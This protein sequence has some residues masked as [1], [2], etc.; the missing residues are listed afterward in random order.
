[1]QFEDESATD[2]WGEPRHGMMP[3]EDAPADRR[4]A[5]LAGDGCSRGPE[6]PEDRPVAGASVHGYS[7]LARLGWRRAGI[8]YEARVEESGRRVILL[9]LPAPLADSARIARFRREAERLVRLRHPHLQEVIAAGVW[10][11]DGEAVGYLVVPGEFGETLPEHLLQRRPDAASRVRLLAGVC[12]GLEHAHR[13]GL[14]HGDLRAADLLV[15]LD[16]QARLCEVGVARLHRIMAGSLPEVVAATDPLP[17]AALPP[18][19]SFRDVLALGE[20]ARSVLSWGDG[21]ASPPPAAGRLREMLAASPWARHEGPLGLARS[22][23]EAVGGSAGGIAAGDRGRRREAGRGLRRLRDASVCVATGAACLS[24][25]LAIAHLGEGRPDLRSTI[26]S[27]AAAPSQGDAGPDR[28]G[29]LLAEDLPAALRSAGVGREV[30]LERALD[31]AAAPLAAEGWAATGRDAAEAAE[32]HEAIAAAYESIG[33]DEAAAS[34]RRL[35]VRALAGEAVPRRLEAEARLARSLLRLRRFEEAIAVLAAAST[36]ADRHLDGDSGITRRIVHDLAVARFLEGDDAAAAIATLSRLRAT[37]ASD[38]PD[39]LGDGEIA[40]SLSAVLEATG[41]IEEAEAMLASSLASDPAASSVPMDAASRQ[42]RL[43]SLRLAAGKPAEA[44]TAAETAFAIACEGLGWQHPA[45]A[46]MAALLAAV[47]DRSGDHRRAAAIAAS[48][49]AAAPQLPAV[50]AASLEL[51][52]MHAWALARGGDLAAADEVVQSLLADLEAEAGPSH[53]LTLSVLASAAA[54]RF[55]AGAEQEAAALAAEGVRRR[56]AAGPAEGA[57]LLRSV[58]EFS[59]IVARSERPSEHRD[60][61][62]S[63]GREVAAASGPDH[64]ATLAARRAHAGV[65]REEGRLDEAVAILEEVAARAI[66]SLPDDDPLPVHCRNDLAY[67]LLLRGDL[68]ASD[69]VLR[70]AWARAAGRGPAFEPASRH[71]GQLARELVKRL[72][73]SDAADADETI[74]FWRER[75]AGASPG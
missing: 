64:P 47:A 17:R 52:R 70:D 4:E 30:S 58:L 55:E 49:L 54:L 31:L 5:P 66:A 71:I 28:L 33:A 43:A 7:I 69:E 29:R 24:I 23:R 16:G 41:R 32:A 45:T 25:G 22:L 39:L 10:H 13:Y 44:L 42:A 19:E 50:A 73:R 12:E 18:E 26:A 46:E 3:A 61:A 34:Q 15:G 11:R 59:A 14:A 8:A 1:M 6:T 27:Q 56:A 53:A 35:A 72:R 60:L 63:L 2:A 38:R 51:R 9:L 74:A 68:A 36:A 48:S 75:I 40:A 65:L 20:I 67:A 21:E 62:E 37:A 57:E